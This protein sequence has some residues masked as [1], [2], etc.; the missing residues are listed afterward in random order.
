[1]TGQP[2]NNGGV[3]KNLNQILMRFF[4]GIIDAEFL[5]AW[6]QHICFMLFAIFLI[7][8]VNSSL[9]NIQAI[10][11]RTLKNY[12]YSFGVSTL[13]ILASYVIWI[14]IKSTYCDNYI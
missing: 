2:E 11:K 1:M 9:R 10:F 8:N 5:P 4:P 3:V 12:A 6:E 13:M 7:S 14:A